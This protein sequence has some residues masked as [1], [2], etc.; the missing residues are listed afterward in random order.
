MVTAITRPRRPRR[1]RRIGVVAAIVVVV[2]VVIVVAS[3]AVVRQVT[4]PDLG[5]ALTVRRLVDAKPGEAAVPSS[6][7]AAGRVS[8][9]GSLSADQLNQRRSG[10]VAV[11]PTEDYRG[12]TV[13][14]LLD[15]D[16]GWTLGRQDIPDKRSRAYPD[17]DRPVL[18][19]GAGASS[20]FG[21]VAVLWDDGW[22]AVRRMSDG[23]PLWQ[24]RV[25]APD[26]APS[27]NWVSHS[28]GLRVVDADSVVVIE[29]AF[30]AARWVV[31][32]RDRA[33]VVVDPG[34]DCQPVGDI[35]ITSYAAY[36][37][38]ACRSGTVSEVTA[39]GVDAGAV[40]WRVSTP[41]GRVSTVPNGDL[42]VDGY[43]ERTLIHS[44]GTRRRLVEPEQPGIDQVLTTFEN[45]YV[46]GQQGGVLRGIDHAE[47]EAHT[48][49]GARTWLVT[50]T[51]VALGHA[52]AVNGDAL[53]TVEGGGATKM[54][55]LV[56]RSV[57]TG[58]Q[59]QRLELG[60]LEGA[61]GCPQEVLGVAAGHVLL[62]DGDSIRLFG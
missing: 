7:H 54:C 56:V 8:F 6:L 46:T 48:L 43:P 15:P 2:L 22:L 50:S 9:S 57:S 3:W 38:A 13:R 49:T 16:G 18:V 10:L 30:D 36:L 51:T 11:A 14:S 37:V 41:N 28:D 47:L 33:A 4:G 62:G 29:G 60:D 55:S 26:V 40:Q 31:V 5:F 24:Q 20:D 44:D 27:Y 42:V 35:P 53:F 34:A 1:A 23:A 12:V 25:A 61:G 58:R 39:F 32:H 45:G 17:Q 52:A 19:I 21:V 59:R